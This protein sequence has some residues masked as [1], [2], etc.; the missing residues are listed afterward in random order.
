MRESELLFYTDSHWRLAL[1]PPKEPKRKKKSKTKRSG[2][3]D[4][5]VKSF[6]ALV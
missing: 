3:T 4:E 6:S 5:S 1:N 2:G